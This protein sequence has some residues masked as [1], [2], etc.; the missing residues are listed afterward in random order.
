MHSLRW[1]L[2]FS[3][4]GC[5]MVGEEIVVK[6]YWTTGWGNLK[7]SFNEQTHYG[8]IVKV[9]VKHYDRNSCGN[10]IFD[11]LEYPTFHC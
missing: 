5:K 4:Y 2:H 3:K 6:G 1:D 7:R 8:I 11:T 10:P 9:L